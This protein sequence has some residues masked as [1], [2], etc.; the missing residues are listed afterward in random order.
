V[1]QL[2]SEQPITL[3]NEFAEVEVSRVNTRNGA[4]LRIFVPSS[5]AEI[6]LCPLELEALTGKDHEFFSG[7]LADGLA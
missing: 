7:L 5:G 2:V 6:L 3:A 1:T 4:R